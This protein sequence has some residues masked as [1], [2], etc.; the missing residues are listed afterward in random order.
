[1]FGMT[2]TFGPYCGYA[3]DTDMPQAAWGSCGK[4]FPGMEVRIV[5]TDSGDPVGAGTVGMIQIRGP[6]MLRGICRRARED[7]FTSSG[8]YPTG[9]LGH[10]DTDGFLFYHGRSDDMFK[11]S[12]A[13]VYPS[14]VEQ[15]LRTIAGVDNA[16]VTNV[17]AAAGERVGAAVVCTD[18]TV[19]ADELRGAARK[20]LSA[21][22]V[23]TVWLVLESDD[24]IPRGATGKPDARGLREMLAHLRH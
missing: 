17:P 2:E 13:T 1:L 19:T 22:K 15:A 24:D 9:D 18:R 3:A 11:V 14:E 5:D 20:L 7:L 23:P 4:P 12:G 21:F 16:F 10:L 6:H 8:F